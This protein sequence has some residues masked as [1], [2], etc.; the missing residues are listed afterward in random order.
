VSSAQVVLLG[1]PGAGKSTAGRT[2]A[3]LLGWTFLDFDQQ[4]EAESGLTV[5]EIFARY[6][7][8]HFRRLEADLTK[9]LAS[10]QQVV[11]A[12]GGG[13]I[14]TP[15]LPTLLNSEAVLIWL[16][17]RPETALARLRA[18]G[19]A[20]PLLQVA[21]PLERIRALL[22][23]REAQYGRAHVAFDTDDLTPRQ[24]AESI[25]EWLKRQSRSVSSS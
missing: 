17:V 2:L 18:T 24:V 7:E 15:D 3:E 5:A 8:P 23:Q 11:F 19:V 14:T 22:E 16:R 25:Y 12:P 4:I 6:G 1:L 13:W 21:E 9:R 20:R 10:R